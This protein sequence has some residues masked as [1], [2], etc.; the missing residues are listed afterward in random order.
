MAS[1][2]SPWI[3]LCNSS[4]CDTFFSNEP[5]KDFFKHPES[6]PEYEI[7]DLAKSMSHLSDNT[8]TSNKD[9]NKFFNNIKSQ[10]NGEPTPPVGFEISAPYRDAVLF[11]SEFYSDKVKLLAQSIPDILSQF[12]DVPTETLFLETII[13]QICFPMHYV[14]NKT[15]RFKY[16][17]KQT[18]MFTDLI[19]FDECRYI[20]DWMPSLGLIENGFNNPEHELIY[21]MALDGLVR[22]TWFYNHDTFFGCSMVDR[23]THG[24]DHITLNKRETMP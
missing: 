18:N 4:Y 6:S 17:A 3:R 7:C 9:Y 12:C 1:T 13:N 14:T 20:Y 2:I 5:S 24:F 10:F 11:K 15:L 19:I 21:R 23:G 22:N 8:I 16:K